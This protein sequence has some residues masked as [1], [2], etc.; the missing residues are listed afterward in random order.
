MFVSSNLGNSWTTSLFYQYYENIK[1]RDVNLLRLLYVINPYIIKINT[2]FFLH[3]F[4]FAHQSEKPSP[5][6]I[7]KERMKSSINSQSLFTLQ[8][9]PSFRFKSTLPLIISSIASI[10]DSKRKELY[11]TSHYLRLVYCLGQSY[12]PP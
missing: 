4:Q 10:G 6:F 11:K 5:R 9:I 3:F 2:T 7:V 12:L 8:T 1:Q